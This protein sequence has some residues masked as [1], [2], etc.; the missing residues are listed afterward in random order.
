MMG[1][2]FTTALLDSVG[3]EGGPR[4]KCC[5]ESRARE[6]PR[7][8]FCDGSISIARHE[9]EG[10]LAVAEVARAHAPGTAPF[11]SVTL[12]ATLEVR[13]IASPF[14]TLYYYLVVLFFELP[15]ARLALIVFRRSV[16]LFLLPHISL[17]C[18]HLAVAV[19]LPHRLEDLLR[20]AAIP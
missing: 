3:R 20:I 14:C 16:L 10:A 4:F 2:F 11:L 19:L 12:H 1:E 17:L 9:R 5:L 18:L 13:H 7:R 6:I 15:P 8:T